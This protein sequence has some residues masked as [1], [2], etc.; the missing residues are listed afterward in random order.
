ME[1]LGL[2]ANILKRRK[3]SRKLSRMNTRFFDSINKWRHTRGYGV[4]SPLA[5]RLV[6]ECIYPDERYAYY[7]DSRI[8]YVFSQ[9]GKTRIHLRLLVRL[10]NMLRLKNITLVGAGADIRKIISEAYPKL[11]IYTNPRT[12]KPS[13]FIVVFDH[14]SAAENWSKLKADSDVGMLLC[15][16]E[17]ADNISSV[18]FGDN[19]PSLTLTGGN[20][21]LFLRREGM[22]PVSYALL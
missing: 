6:K 22:Q 13:D 16:E 8:D 20:F 10:I 1:F 19:P 3:A 14:S 15:R 17:I 21:T 5:F 7:A 11:Q 4:H 2:R 12:S 18:C 9:Y